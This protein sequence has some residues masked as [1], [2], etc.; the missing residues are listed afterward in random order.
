MDADQL[1]AMIADIG[2]GRLSAKLAKKAGGFAPP[3]YI[4]NAIKFVVD[5]V[6]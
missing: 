3:D 6:Q 5:R 2:K 1:L 4:G